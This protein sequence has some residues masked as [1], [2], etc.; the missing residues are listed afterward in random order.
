MSHFPMEKF[1]NGDIDEKI[2]ILENCDQKSV[3]ESERKEI[4]DSILGIYPFGASLLSREQKLKV[5]DELSQGSWSRGMMTVPSRTCSTILRLAVNSV[6]EK[7]EF[8]L[9]GDC[10]S[11]IKYNGDEYMIDGGVLDLT[12]E[13]LLEGGLDW[14]KD[15]FFMKSVKILKIL[16]ICDY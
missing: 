6:E 8:D 1:V 14:T 5:C 13:A 9:I 10:Y 15:D 12:F 3:T 7:K 11:T 4:R 16:K 2:S